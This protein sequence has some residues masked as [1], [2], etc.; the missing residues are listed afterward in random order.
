MYVGSLRT[1]LIH[2][3]VKE[4]S[5]VTDAERQVL[6]MALELYKATC[7]ANYGSL[8]NPRWIDD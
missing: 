8:G 5:T 7:E 1:Q 2:D 4:D 6:E 3:L